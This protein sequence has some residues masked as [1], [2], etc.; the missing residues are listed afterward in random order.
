MTLTP[1][2]LDL[3][4]GAAGGWSLGLHR[5][6]FH[7]VAACEIDPWRRAVFA[8]NFPHVRIYDDVRGLSAERLISDLGSLPDIVVGSPPCQDASTANT[9]GKGVDGERTGLIFEAIR[10]IREC[11]PR[12]CALEN[13]LGLRTRGAD[14]VLGALEAIDYA[15]WPFVVGGDDIGSPQKRKRVW[16]IASDPLQT[17]TEW[18]NKNGRRFWRPEETARYWPSPCPTEEQMGRSGQPWSDDLAKVGSLRPTWGGGLALHRRVADG[19]STRMARE[20]ISAYGD[21]VIPQITESIGR[22]I[23]RVESA[24]ASVLEERR[25]A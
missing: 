17:I 16:I 5:A 24:L 18:R 8:Q 1:S 25:R 11:R 15:A 9:K 10:L 19:I 7:T 2:I 14:R 3:F 21:A 23:W 12:W 22:A 6:G 13:V 4:S 20:C